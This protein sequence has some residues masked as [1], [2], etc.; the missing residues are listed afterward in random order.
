M[1]YEDIIPEGLK[2]KTAAERRKLIRRWEELYDLKQDILKGEMP[3]AHEQLPEIERELSQLNKQLEPREPVPETGVLIKGDK[4]YILCPR[5][6]TFVRLTKE[7]ISELALEFKET[8]ENGRAA[9]KYLIRSVTCPVCKWA[10]GVPAHLQ[11][12]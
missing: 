9:D 10:L 8:P 1:E 12:L 6:G 7:R 3:E 4:Q 2:G 11:A 5:C